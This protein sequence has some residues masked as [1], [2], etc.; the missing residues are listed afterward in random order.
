MSGVYFVKN[1]SKSTEDIMYV[2]IGC[3]KDCKLRFK[4]IQSTNRFVGSKDELELIQIIPCVQYKK[5][6]RHLHKILDFSR[7]CGEWFILSEEKLNS[8]LF[9]ISLSDYK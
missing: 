5:L 9:L 3:S 4:Q 2:K 7:C 1:V 8:R 6:E